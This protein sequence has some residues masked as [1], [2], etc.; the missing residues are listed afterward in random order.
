M[1]TAFIFKAHWGVPAIPP[2][3]VGGDTC[4]ADYEQQREGHAEWGD[5]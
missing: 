1:E 4:Q 3:Y 5:F 2:R